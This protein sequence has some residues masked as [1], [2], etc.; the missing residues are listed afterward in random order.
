MDPDAN[1]ARQLEI[2]NEISNIW[3]GLTD[4]GGQ[5][6]ME[7]ATSD[8]GIELAELVEALNRWIT[9]GGFLPKEWRREP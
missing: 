4:H 7:Q 5:E 9:R 2:S 6:E 8:L 3:A 1:L